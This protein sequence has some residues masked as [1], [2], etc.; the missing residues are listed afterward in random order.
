M[1]KIVDAIIEIPAGSR[2]K[3]EIDKETNIIKLDRVLYSS[4]TYPAEYGYIP[5]TLSLDGDPLDILVLSSEPTFP[6]CV[7]PARVVGYLE[8]IDRGFKDE[9]LIA[10]P[11]VDPRFNHVTD[12]NDI[13]EHQ[14]KEIKNFF[15]T[16]KL[17]QDMEVIVNDFH[18]SKEAETLI[19]EAM[20]RAQ[21]KS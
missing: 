10:V 14:L 3:Y 5:N 11:N 4:V 13:P 18:N 12:I 20:T 9:K 16:Y 15:A 2:N 7:V 6:G 21:K 8:A 1:V 19:E 17:L